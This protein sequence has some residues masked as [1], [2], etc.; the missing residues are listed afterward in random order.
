[1]ISLTYHYMINSFAFCNRICLA[2]VCRASIRLHSLCHWG[3]LAAISNV[4]CFY[5]DSL[6]PPF[7]VT[8]NE[9]RGKKCE[10]TVKEAKRK[11]R[12][13]NSRQKQQAKEYKQN[14]ARLLQLEVHGDAPRGGWV[15][16]T[17][18]GVTL[19]LA[20]ALALFLTLAYRL[21]SASETDRAGGGRRERG[22]AVSQFNWQLSH[23]R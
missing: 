15:N 20:L 4:S 3:T 5:I 2:V 13:R 6:P 1:M 14:A 21:R 11:R 7:D 18:C 8:R 23:F 10:W 9:W 17:K 19:P 12:A 16:N 22:K